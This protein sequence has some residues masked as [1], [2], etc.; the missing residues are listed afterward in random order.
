[1]CNKPILFLIFKRPDVTA[2]VLAAIRQAQPSK[3]YIA[4]DGARPDKE[5]ETEKVAQTR[6][7]VLN[8]IDWPCE[9]KTLLRETNLG[10]RMAVSSAIDWF[11]EHEEEGIILEDDCLPDQSF[12]RF[13]EELLEYYRHDTRVMAISGDNFQQGQQRGKYSYYFSQLP[14]CWGWATWRRAWRLYHISIKYFEEIM[15]EPIYREFTHHAQFNQFRYKNIVNA[16]KKEL[17]SWAFLW[18]FA[19]H[20]NH[21]LAILPQ[22]N[23]VENIGF[24]EDATHT[25]G[26]GGKLR[27]AAQNIAFPLRHPPYVCHH[28]AADTFYVETYLKLTPRPKHSVLSR[29]NNKIRRVIRDIVC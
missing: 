24:G 3:L 29:I 23:L 16:Y 13:C 14:H 2:Q 1:M 25:T 22:C 28:K 21:G 6:E 17:D 19:N 5:G 27:I 11:F 18:G 15:A 20:A 12:F 7:L 10:C 26:K 8:G 9:V 4:A